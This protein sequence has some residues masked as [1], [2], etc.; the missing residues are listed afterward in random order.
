MAIKNTNEHGRAQAKA[1]YGSL[2]GTGIVTTGAM[3]QTSREAPQCPEDA[4][5]EPVYTNM[6]KGHVRGAP[7]GANPTMTNEVGDNYPHGGFDKKGS[8]TGRR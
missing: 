4:R 6:A 8:I 3:D 1:R 7:E 5:R 2:G